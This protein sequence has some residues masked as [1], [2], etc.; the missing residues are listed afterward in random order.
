MNLLAWHYHHRGQQDELQWWVVSVSKVCLTLGLCSVPSEDGVYSSTYRV[1]SSQPKKMS[2]LEDTYLTY[3]T[4]K[5]CNTFL[6]PD[7]FI[8]NV[9]SGDMHQH[10]MHF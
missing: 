1:I 2:T 10:H 7:L 8:G 6:Q 3:Y 5:F 9:I 4:F